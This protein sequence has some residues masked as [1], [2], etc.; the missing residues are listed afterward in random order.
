MM[1]GGA[2]TAAAQFYNPWSLLNPFYELE[3]AVFTGLGSSDR[4]GCPVTDTLRSDTR[5]VGD[6]TFR[7]ASSTPG[8]RGTR[9]NTWYNIGSDDNSET[10][11]RLTDYPPSADYKLESVSI[12]WFEVIDGVQYRRSDENPALAVDPQTGAVTVTGAYPIDTHIQ[13][14][15]EGVPWSAKEGSIQ[16]SGGGFTV[17]GMDPQDWP[18]MEGNSFEVLK[19]PL[20]CGPV[21][22]YFTDND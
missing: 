5:T 19:S 20:T 17:T 13:F 7:K 9:F 10:I 12:R 21:K 16:Q 15:Y 1:V 14:F 11:H 3:S 18:V 4:V 22:E 8:Y 2:G 6:V